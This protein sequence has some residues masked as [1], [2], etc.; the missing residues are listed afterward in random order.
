MLVARSTWM[1]VTMLLFALGGVGLL[2]CV[3]KWRDVETRGRVL[4]LALVLVGLGGG[5]T[6]YGLKRDVIL[7]T[8][9]GA[10]VH[11]E[12]LVA[13]FHSEITGTGTTWIVNRSTHTLR[14]EMIAYGKAERIAPTLIPPGT[15]H[16]ENGP[17][18]Y[19]GPDTEA[20]RSVSV[21]AGNDA[22]YEAWLTW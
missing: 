8:G 10:V 17:I 21:S 16:V 4:L 20:P 19:V 6:S 22:A 2:V 3:R 9:D 11:S 1:I 18:V 5:G 12:R 7:C 14:L 15:I 13:I